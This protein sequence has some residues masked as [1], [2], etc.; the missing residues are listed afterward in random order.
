[1]MTSKAELPQVIA[2]LD[3]LRR[4]SNLLH[5]WQKQAR[6]GADDSQDDQQLDQRETC[7]SPFPVTHPPSGFHAIK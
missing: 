7:L 3:R 1:M 4:R 5:R 6:Q 2:A